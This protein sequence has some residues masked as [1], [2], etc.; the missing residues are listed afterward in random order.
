MQPLSYPSIFLLLL[1]LSCLGVEGVG[2][3]VE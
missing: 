1:L 2:V 3:E